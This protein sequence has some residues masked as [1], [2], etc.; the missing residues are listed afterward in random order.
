MKKSIEL[1]AGGG[2]LALGLEQ[3]GFE[4]VGL[5]EWDKFAAET[6][7][8]NRPAWNVIQ[9]DA[10]E[11]ASQNLELLFGLKKG[12]L[13][14]LSGG[15][16]CQSFSQA[17]KRLGLEDTRGT[18][19]YHYATFLHK[20][21]PKMFLFENVRGLET[22][23]KGK[24]YQTIL[25]IFEN[26]G[27]NV[28]HQVLNAWDYCVPQKR[29]RLITIGIRK[30]LDFTFTFPKPDDTHPVLKDIC[31]ET[32]PPREE[33]SRYP[34]SKAKLFAMIPQDGNW[35]CLP[36]ALAKAYMKTCYEA[37]GGRTGVLKRCSL[38]KP[39]PTIMTSPSMK[40]T[41]RC[42]PLETRPFSY[43]ENA[44]IQ[45]FP[46]SWQFYGP[47]GAKYKQVGNAV[48]VNLAKAIGTAILDALSQ[49]RG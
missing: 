8:R 1:F 5:V 30:D 36:P 14:L 43:R 33:C 29:E 39:S 28:Q 7:R 22:H 2:G 48:P 40:Q 38:D 44:R 18:M 12:E 42:H 6:L 11:V 25:Q 41:E 24:T 45:T 3:A 32:D 10:G 47:L 9:E 34:E 13:D 49:E 4:H 17:G 31:L 15:A 21:Q 46:D 27:Y 19:F 37:G 26:E 20:L 23:D 35:R 16:P